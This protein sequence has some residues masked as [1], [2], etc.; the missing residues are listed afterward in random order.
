MDDEAAHS[1]GTVDVHW[2]SGTALAGEI[3]TTQVPAGRQLYLAVKWKD[4]PPTPITALLDPSMPSAFQVELSPPV[5]AREPVYSRICEGDQAEGLL[6][7]YLTDQ[8]SPDPSRD[9]LV[10]ASFK[11]PEAFAYVQ[12]AYNE[13]FVW[14]TCAGA[15]Y[16]PPLLL[17][18]DPRLWIA[19]CEVN[20][21]L[22]CG[23][24][25]FDRTHIAGAR[26][27]LD[28]S[29]AHLSLDRVGRPASLTLEVNGVETTED[30]AQWRA[31]SNT[32]RVTVAGLAPWEAEVELPAAP[33]EPR[34]RETS[35]RAGAEFT[36]RW[37]APW[38]ST[39][40]VNIYPLDVPTLKVGDP[41][42][43]A[44]GESL[45]A[46]FPGFFDGYGKPRDVPRARVSLRATRVQES[47]WLSTTEE[48]VLS[49]EN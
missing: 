40:W 2:V 34:A 32:V 23:K 45:T 39:A 46:T 21:A 24:R 30:K 28:A 6:L 29:G 25:I 37:T 22:A 14:S 12:T 8:P 20:G 26:L 41:F 38:A 47:F 36:L 1:W 9:E 17:Q 16:V 15:R 48:L 35:L 7:A 44:T 31:G 43:S 5:S 3:S 11:Q 19:L 18:H 10:G 4:L 33:L 49:V 13:R 27:D 42:F